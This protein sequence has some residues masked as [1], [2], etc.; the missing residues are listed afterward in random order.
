MRIGIVLTLATAG[1]LV[2]L[3]FFAKQFHSEL[4]LANVIAFQLSFMWTCAEILD[5]PGDDLPSDEPWGGDFS[6]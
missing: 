6:H 4:V 5:G 1:S 2:F 3:V